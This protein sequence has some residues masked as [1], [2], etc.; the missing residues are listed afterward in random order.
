MSGSS[1]ISFLVKNWARLAYIFG[2]IDRNKVK[3]YCKQVREALTEDLV[4]TYI[5][6]YSK[7]R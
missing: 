2:T 5:G 3:N 4:P 7:S 6:A 1:D